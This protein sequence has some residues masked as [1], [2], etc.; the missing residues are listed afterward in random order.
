MVLKANLEWETDV[1]V[2]P[3]VVDD[4]WDDTRRRLADGARSPLSEVGP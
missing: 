2:A 1:I 4:Y 3:A